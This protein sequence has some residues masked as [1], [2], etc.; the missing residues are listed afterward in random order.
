MSDTSS[1]YPAAQVITPGSPK[2]PEGAQQAA[3]DFDYSFVSTPARI[4]VYDDFLSEPRLFIV[5]AAPTTD[6]IGAL[7]ATI[8]QQAQAQGGAISY[9][10]ILQ[11]TENFIHARFS[12]M[13]V[14]I[15]N[16]GKTIRFSDQGPGFK[17][18]E[19]ALEP[20]FSSAT[21]PMKRYIK[22]VGSGLP[23]VKEWLQMA[24]TGGRITIEDNL[25]GGAV[26]TISMGAEG[27][28]PEPAA[29]VR[30]PSFYLPP[31]TEKERTYILLFAREGALGITDIS[32]LTEYPKATI[33]E[34]L[35]RLAEAGI[36]QLEPGSKRRML[37]VMG[38][39]VAE[40]LLHS[41]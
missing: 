8:Y 18:K 30:K 1:Y 17:N 38:D 3:S 27:Q 40:N 4:A 23:T 5:D 26:V 7:A 15:Y 35:R 41:N 31:L 16:G 13:V 21:Q 36:I 28:Q 32:K 20:G 22:G 6:F 39:Q 10:I 25:N 33:Y 14:S 29:P 9:S 11:V 12:E 19:R 34:D 24:N 2:I 37:T